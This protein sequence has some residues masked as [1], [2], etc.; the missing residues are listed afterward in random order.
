MQADVKT[1]SRSIRV[2]EENSSTQLKFTKIQLIAVVRSLMA[3]LLFLAL[4]VILARTY[5][6]G[7]PHFWPLLKATGILI[8]V[9]SIAFLSQ[10]TK[11]SQR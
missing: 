9:A 5:V 10:S 2:S 6:S 11:K 8:M 4:G 3:V 1:A 7:S